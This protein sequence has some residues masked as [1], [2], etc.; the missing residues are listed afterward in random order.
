MGL[1]LDIV[2]KYVQLS[3]HML[4]GSASRACRGS[5]TRAVAEAA[6]LPGETVPA[7]FGVLGKY[8]RPVRRHDMDAIRRSIARGIAAE[9]D[10]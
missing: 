3:S 2:L 6:L 9:R 10:V 7:W 8:A 1:L 4:A 5:H